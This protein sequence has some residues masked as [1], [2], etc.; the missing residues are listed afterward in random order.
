MKVPAMRGLALLLVSVITGSA[1]SALQPLPI[2][3]AS[4]AK[5]FAPVE[6]DISPDGTWVAYT[7]IDPRRR[8]LQGIPSDQWKV[9]TCTGVPYSLANTDLLISNTKTGQT[10]NISSGQGANWSPSWSPDGK[11]LA[12]Y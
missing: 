10:I 6:F 7:L 2:E 4:T 12:F 11:S 5:S 9:F 8:K 1:Q 3:I